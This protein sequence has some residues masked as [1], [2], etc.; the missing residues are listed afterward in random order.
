MQKQLKVGESNRES[1]AHAHSLSGHQ[2]RRESKSPV[3]P[4][5]AS[6]HVAISNSEVSPCGR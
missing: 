2:R 6:S 1:S 4:E 3:Q 5:H